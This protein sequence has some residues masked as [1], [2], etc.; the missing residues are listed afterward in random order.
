MHQ[1]DSVSMLLKKKEQWDQISSRQ[2]H[3][4]N[5][6]ELQCDSDSNM[7][8]DDLLNIFEYQVL[9]VKNLRVYVSVHESQNKCGCDCFSHAVLNWKTRITKEQV[10]RECELSASKT[11]CF[12]EWQGPQIV[13]SDLSD[14]MRQDIYE[15]QNVKD[16]M[17][18]STMNVDQ[19]E[20]RTVRFADSILK[21]KEKQKTE[22]SDESAVLKIKNVKLADVLCR[23]TEQNS[24]QIVQKMLC[25]V[26]SDI[27]VENILTSESVTHKLMFKSE[28][29]NVIM[30]ISKLNKINVNS[31]KTHQ[32]SNVLYSSASSQVIV[33][34]KNEHVSV[35]LDFRAEVNLMQKSVLQKLGV[36]YTVNIWLRLVNIN[37]D[38][39][40]L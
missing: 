7:R 36:L 10:H 6:L 25:A 15:K 24:V 27:T 13:I 3:E 2:H 21:S 38:E 18:D 26:I 35:L 37:E 19:S 5:L 40:M 20:S 8:E 9:S 28:K 34:V 23:V 39:I 33:K 16:D 22:I 17:S 31:I 1:L 4:T 12:R 30:K 32:L 11:L 14:R 29:F